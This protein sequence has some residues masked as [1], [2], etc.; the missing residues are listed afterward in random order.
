MLIKP[1]LLFFCM[2]YKD[3]RCLQFPVSIESLGYLIMYMSW[4]I[5]RYIEKQARNPVIS[6]KRDS[7]ALCE[8]ISQVVS[9]LRDRVDVYATIPFEALKKYYLNSWDI[10]ARNHIQYH[11]EKLV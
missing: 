2:I 9:G 3:T 1:V 7:R 8:H 6:V 4:A 11:K 10:L 5:W